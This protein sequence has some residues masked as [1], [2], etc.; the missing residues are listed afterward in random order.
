MPDIRRTTFVVLSSVLLLSTIYSV[1][2]HTYLDTSNPLIA[3]GHAPH[4]LH[5][6]SYFA[7]KNN[8]LNT[9][10]IKMAWAWTSAAA[11]ALAT[12]APR[13]RTSGPYTMP[14][15][16]RLR[17]WGAATAV[18]FVF[19]S[20]FFGPALLARLTALSGGE[21]VVLLPSG[22]VHPVPVSFCYERSS[23][24]LATHPELFQFPPL[25]LEEALIGDWHTRP[26]LMRGHDVSGHIFLL[27][28]GVL[29]LADMLRPSLALP[30]DSRPSAHGWAMFGTAVLM[31]T[32]IF[33]IFTTGMFYHTP[34]EKLTGYLLGLAGFLFTQLRYF[35]DPTPNLS[36][37]YKD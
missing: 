32:S 27:T 15:S 16:E 34:S 6:S 14:I 13:T 10:F 36:R 29:F 25:M 23:V 5:N 2:H 24:S 33:S 12:T 26:R 19:A 28:M 22:L 30:R 37:T 35:R 18:W 21:C 9:V 8:V 7:R 31:C 20:W 17:K 4:P 11:L 1:A 3:L